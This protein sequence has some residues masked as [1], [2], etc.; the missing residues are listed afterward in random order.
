MFAYSIPS[1]GSGIS[2]GN[3]MVVSLGKW[4]PI[5]G[6]TP[7]QQAGT[8]M[9][10]LGHTLGLQD[11]GADDINFKPKLFQCHELCLAD[12]GPAVLLLV[13]LDA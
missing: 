5:A 4:A 7:E 6:G 2:R 9:H 12:A 3:D 10:E 13:E 11:G 1:G 8:L